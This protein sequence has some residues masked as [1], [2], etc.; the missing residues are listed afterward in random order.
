MIVN[1][2]QFDIKSKARV[3]CFP[4]L[5]GLKVFWV[6]MLSPSCIHWSS[7]GAREGW[8]GAQNLPLICWAIACR[9]ACYRPHLAML[10]CTPQLD[11]QWLSTLSKMELTWFSTKKGPRDVGV[12]TGGKR[13]WA[14]AA[15]GKLVF[16]ADPFLDSTLQ[17]CI[18]R[19][20]VST[21]HIFLH[22][23]EEQ[24]QTFLKESFSREHLQ[25][26]PRRAVRPEDFLSASCSARLHFHRLR[27]ARARLDDPS[28]LATCGWFDISQNVTWSKKPDGCLP[29]QTTSSLIWCE[30]KERVLL[31]CELVAAQGRWTGKRALC[32]VMI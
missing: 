20:I 26:H 28:L 11:L 25:V 17:K 32:R 7:Q 18:L 4:S 3:A 23:S 24:I 21:P 19:S 27:M 5:E 15:S 14:T 30:D 10:E 16:K 8:L 9:Q 31:P 2:E 12:P 6:E 22:A 29:R 1:N 13:I